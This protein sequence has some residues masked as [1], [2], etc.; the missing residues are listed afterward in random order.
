VLHPLVTKENIRSPLLGMLK[1]DQIAFGVNNENQ[2][3]DVK[4]NLNLSNADWV[5]DEVVAEGF[6]E[7]H[8]FGSTNRA[9]LLFNYD[10]GIE[11]EILQYLEGPN[12]LDWCYGSDLPRLCHIGMHAVEGNNGFPTH[13]FG[14]EICQKVTTI[15]HTNPAV[16]EANRRY[17]YTIYNAT[18]ILGTCLKTIKRLS[19]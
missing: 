7:A 18:K 17:E 6:V 12:Y 9:R 3:K 4:R 8:G 16:N 15:S 11:V 5:E 19:I 14:L 2:V 1:I 13:S 10:L